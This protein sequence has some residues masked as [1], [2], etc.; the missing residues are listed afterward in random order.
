MRGTTDRAALIAKARE[1][2]GDL[3]DSEA[4]AEA[5]RL[6]AGLTAE[7][8]DAEREL[9]IQDAMIRT[10]KDLFSTERQFSADALAMYNALCPRSITNA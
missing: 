2:P 7:L 8:A 10:A 1:Y 4:I 6:L 9:A 3:W 5:S